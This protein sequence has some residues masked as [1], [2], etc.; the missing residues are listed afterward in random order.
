[1]SAFDHHIGH[2]QHFTRAS[3]TAP[4][5]QSG[6]EVERVTL[7]GFPFFNLYRGVVIARGEKLATDVTVSRSVSLRNW[8]V[9]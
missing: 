1:M 3:I 9:L 6:F 4:L 8:Q 7:S 5:Q 2:R